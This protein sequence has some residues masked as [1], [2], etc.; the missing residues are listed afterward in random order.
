MASAID[1]CNEALAVIGARS[2][3]V[4]FDEASKEAVNCKLFYNATRRALIRAAHWGFARKQLLLTEEQGPATAP[5]PW[6]YKYAYPA[7]CERV[8]YI[9]PM[10]LGIALPDDV[11]PTD[12]AFWPLPFPCR[13]WRFIVANNVDSKSILTNVQYAVG[14]YTADVQDVDLFDSLFHEAFVNALAAKLTLPIS[15]NVQ[16]MSEW[17]ALANDAILVA[18]AADGNEA[19]PSTDHTPDWIVARGVPAYA[20]FNDFVGAGQA[21]LWYQGPEAWGM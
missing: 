21:G 4:S 7:D 6:G 2:Q 19:M 10:P 8:R 1:I 16:M 3:I 14:V 17:K 20:A 11:I 5:Y 15:G 9:V 13:Q 12:A 18:R